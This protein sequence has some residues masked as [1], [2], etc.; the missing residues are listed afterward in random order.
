M[1]KAIIL[2]LVVSIPFFG[3]TQLVENI[4]YISPFHNDIAAVKKDEQWAFINLKGEIIIDYRNDLVMTE[5]ADGNFPI[6]KSDRCLIEDKRDGISY[7]GYIN[8]CGKMVIEPQFLNA[9]NFNEGSAI[10]LEVFKEEVARNEA[11]GKSIVYYK[12]LQGIIDTQG[13]IKAYL[14]PERVNVI[15][16]KK[17]LKAPPEI[18]SKY[19]SKDLY[20]VKSKNNKWTV[21][22]L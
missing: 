19:I 4:D 3:F 21:I 8:T 6:F 12:Y 5:T 18:T 14:S 20:A 13:H 22:K 16:D 15:L 7:F 9:T 10:V 1:K 2:F 17:F 11:L